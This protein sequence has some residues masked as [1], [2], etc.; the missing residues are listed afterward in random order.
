MILAEPFPSKGF[1]CHN[2]FGFTKRSKII[3][4][5]IK[6]VLNRSLLE[7]VKWIKNWELTDLLISVFLKPRPQL[8]EFISEISTSLRNLSVSY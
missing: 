6:I 3:N 4:E 7:Q 1:T 2:I 5:I 8:V